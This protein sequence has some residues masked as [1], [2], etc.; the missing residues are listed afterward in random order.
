[1]VGGIGPLVIAQAVNAAGNFVTLT[2]TARHLGPTDY[3]EYAVF[4]ATA[5]V[6][7]QVSDAG[8]SRA[9]TLVAS[10]LSPAQDRQ[11]LRRTYMTGWWV[12]AA[13]HMT[14][15]C[16]FAMFTAI[17]VLTHH[18]L[19]AYFALG[20]LAGL[21]VSLALFA[22]GVL[23]AERRFHALALLNGLPGVLRA[24]IV[25]GFALSGRLGLG[26][27]AAAYTLGPVLALALVIMRLGLFDLRSVR[28]GQP[29]L[30]RL[31]VAGRWIALAAALEVL[32]QRVDVIG[33]RVLST[34]TETGI[35]AGAFL[36]IS[37]INFVIL[38][39]NAQAYPALVAA[40]ER[41][42][43]TALRQVFSA[44]TALLV[45][46]GV[47]LVCAVATIFPDLATGVLG[48][49]YERSVVPMRLLAVYGVATVIQFNC[50]AL[51]LA[52]GRSSWVVMWSLLLALLESAGIVLAV[53]RYGAAGAAAAV[54]VAML[55]MLPLSWAWVTRLIGF[56]IP[57]RALGVTAVLAGLALAGLGVASSPRPLPDLVL[58]LVIWAAVAGAA[59]LVSARQTHPL[60]VAA[61]RR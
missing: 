58:K 49:A 61:R 37:A 2:V 14:V 57:L 18:P 41:R 28:P 15:I 32:Y 5:L 53:P 39:V 56:A 23:Q 33:L 34:P 19:L 4:L 3:G 42:D 35:Y 22:A 13:T 52:V 12:R 30:R 6:V 60:F 16:L 55:L 44:S 1:V 50:G 17:A 7:A 46:I 21:A 45:A 36:F 59:L 20:S 27:A 11:E 51:F 43:M 26:T 10:R 24:L 48:V 9:I 47:P 38:A 29:Q 54:A 40:A 31:W 8:L 25:I